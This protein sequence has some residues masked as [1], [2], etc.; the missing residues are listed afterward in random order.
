M[1]EDEVRYRSRL[2][3]MDDSSRRGIVTGDE[4]TATQVCLSW[5]NPTKLRKDNGLV[6]NKA[7]LC[8][9]RTL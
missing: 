4:A 2:I 8:V 6:L 1:D 7:N 9:S 5:S 3:K